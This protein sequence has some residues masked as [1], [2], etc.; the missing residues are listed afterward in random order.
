[1]PPPSSPV[2]RLSSVPYAASTVHTIS[3]RS[4][5]T[6]SHHHRMKWRPPRPLLGDA[7]ATTSQHLAA[8][9]PTTSSRAAPRRSAILPASSSFPS[10]PSG[11]EEGK[12][13]GS[14]RTG[15]ERTRAKDAAD[16]FARSSLLSVA[17]TVHALA[18]SSL[19]SS[20]A[21]PV[22][23]RPD[24]VRSL[25]SVRPSVFLFIV[26]RSPS[27]LLTAKANASRSL[28]HQVTPSTEREGF[29]PSGSGRDT[30][31]TTS[32][33]TMNMD[34]RTSARPSA[35][36]SLPVWY[37]VREGRPPSRAGHPFPL[38]LPTLSTLPWCA[39]AYGC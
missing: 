18:R 12:S 17:I 31:A 10:N 16:I 19:P 29:T 35:R 20:S 24:L 39:W 25:S 7:I 28:S 22:I 30:I 1:M 4:P 34:G 5:L 14:N 23:L 11:G 33:P 21:V 37:V 15:R 3:S 8:D 36:L 13:K 6:T 32:T 27:C 9:R 26:P 2:P 38:T